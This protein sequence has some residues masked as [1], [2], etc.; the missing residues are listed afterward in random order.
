[1][2]LRS[3]KLTIKTDRPLNIQ[4]VSL[5]GFIGKRFPEL[6]LLHN[7]SPDTSFIYIFPRVQYRIFN[8]EVLIIGIE[9]GVD[10]VKHIEPALSELSLNRETYRIVE[11]TGIEN[12]VYFGVVK[13]LQHYS[14]LTPWLALNEKNYEKYQKLGSWA[15]KKEL[16]EKILI[17][18]IISMSK[19]LGYTVP[20]PIKANFGKLKEVQTKLKGTHM[21][22]FLGTFS[23]NFE[24]PD[25]WGIGK[26]VS[27]GFGTI[28]RTDHQTKENRPD[29]RHK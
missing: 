8:C 14:F 7:H 27:R 25:Y 24:I 17:G 11:K 20:E 10:A 15:N 3:Y 29:D 26:S 21:L 5:R 6:S 1:M 22:G 28:I 12:E 4:A 2:I 16:L 9:E 13:D 19:S 18:N 23:V